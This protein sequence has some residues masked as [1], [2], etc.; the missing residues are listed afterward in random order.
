MASNWVDPPKRER[1]QRLN[2]NENE[3]FKTMRREK[4]DRSAGPR[5]PRMPPLQVGAGV[6]LGY[7]I[8]SFYDVRMKD[9]SRSPRCWSY[10]A[11]CSCCKRM[12]KRRD[13]AEG[14]AAL[15]QA[16]LAIER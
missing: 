15:L 3:L 12:Q 6:G 10:L 13:W 11:P 5:L 4:T 8:L 2:L 14:R 16:T 9:D 1:K 7:Y